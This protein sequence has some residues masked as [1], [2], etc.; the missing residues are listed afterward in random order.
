MSLEQD[1]RIGA[2]FEAT[3]GKP[4]FEATTSAMLQLSLD[5]RCASAGFDRVILTDP[6]VP[7][8]WDVVAT[9]G[10]TTPLRFLKEAFF[11]VLYPIASKWISVEQDEAG[12][13]SFISLADIQVALEPGAPPPKKFTEADVKRIA[14]AMPTEL[15]FAVPPEAPD[16]AEPARSVLCRHGRGTNYSVIPELSLDERRCVILCDERTL[17]RELPEELIFESLALIV[18]CHEAS[19]DIAKYKAGSCS[20]EQPPALITTAVHQWR[21]LSDTNPIALNESIQTQMWERLQHGSVAVHCL[22][23]IH[24]AAC[25]VACHFLWRH[26]RLGHDVP[27]DPQEIYRRLIA[28]R[29]AVSPAYQHVLQGYENYL[30][31]GHPPPGT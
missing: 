21:N 9:D 19:C 12:R 1:S 3:V 27:S 13:H 30:K 16:A 17:C 22:A 4:Q 18:N 2:L 20:T 24:R 26:Y 11:E 14:E 31:S 29:P 6:T 7:R 15:L 28:V 23:G 8:S 10:K 25:I 5:A